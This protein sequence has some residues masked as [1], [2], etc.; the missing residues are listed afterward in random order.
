MPEG[1]IAFDGK[2][3][4]YSKGE[5]L[6]IDRLAESFKEVIIIS[7]VLREGD[8]FYESCIHSA[9]KS[10]NISIK[11]LPGTHNKKIS[12]FRKSL[13]FLFLFYRILIFSR[14]ADLFYFFLP[15]YP[16]FL[17]WVS[18]KITGKKHIVY[19][20]DDWQQASESMFKW[21]H[22]KNTYFYHLYC[23]LNKKM[24]KMIVGGA[25]FSVTAG[26]QL[27]QKYENFGCPSY[28]TTPR[29][30]LSAKDLYIRDDT[31]NNSN[32]VLVTVGGLIHDK[33]QHILIEAFALAEARDKSLYLKIIGEGPRKDELNELCRNLHIEEKVDFVGYVEDERELLNHLRSSD[34]FVLSSVTEG[35]PRVFYESMASSLPIVT[36]NVGGIPYLLE[37][38]ETAL[39]VEPNDP[40]QI[41]QAIRLISEDGD[42]RRTIIKKGFETINNIFQEMSSSQI[43]DLVNEHQK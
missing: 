4:R 26:G 34:A 2:E 9:F 3:Y 11:E 6:Y 16:S 14:K 7:F 17:G 40:Y 22:L 27:K 13:Q 8:P 1:P 35:F 23:W 30:T 5:R 39:I 21:D 12:V 18:C 25:M 38:N 31:F 33:A 15:S 41:S 37:N 10:Q 36:T 32:K 19:G 24:E 29:M 20:A 28:P 42:L 43:A